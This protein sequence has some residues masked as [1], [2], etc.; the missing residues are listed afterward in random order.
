MPI[1]CEEGHRRG[2]WPCWPGILAAAVLIPL[3]LALSLPRWGSSKRP[4]PPRWIW[5]PS[6][7]KR[8]RSRPRP[9]IS[10]RASAVKEES[11]LAVDVTADNSFALFLDGKP[12][13]EG[14]DWATLQRVETKLGVGPHVLAARASNEAPGAGG[15][16]GQGRRAAAGA[17]GARPDR[18]HLEEHG[19]GTRGDGWTQV[20][21]DD[22]GW[23]RAVDLGPLGSAP[24]GR[25]ASSGESPSERFRVPD[26]FKIETVASPAVTGSV[27]A[28]TFDPDGRPCVSI[29]QGPIARL[30]D[31]DR[32]G[33]F[34]R[35]QP[36][37]TGDEQ[38]PGALVHPGAPLRR[39]R[40]P[41]G[42]G[43]LSARRPEP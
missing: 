41:Q 36:I 13:A 15:P 4:T 25:L 39:G 12:A 43:T 33:R 14:N 24:W 27:V 31:D 28:F 18:R 32:D 17:G 10:A 42:D 30:F 6:G 9:A 23:A 20:E 2:R 26:G 37:T 21:F 29:E 22:R 34:D 40:R 3:A 11:R 38:L 1:E 7:P 35:R 19:P 5:H 8:I 16:A